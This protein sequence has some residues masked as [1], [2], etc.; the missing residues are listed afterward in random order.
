MNKLSTIGERIEHLRTEKRATQ[1]ELAASIGV[2]RETIHQWESG[3]RDLKT[4]AIIKLAQHFNVSA[5][6]LLGLSDVMAFD[7]DTQRLHSVTGLS[8]DAIKTLKEWNDGGT[9]TI[10]STS[11]R[12]G[13]VETVSTSTNITATVTAV[14]D[15]VN[16]LLGTEHGSE[17]LHAMHEYLAFQIPVDTVKIMP[18]V[19]KKHDSSSVEISSKVVENALFPTVEQSLSRLKEYTRLSGFYVE[20]EKRA[21]ERFTERLMLINE[22]S[23]RMSELRTKGGGDNGKHSE[24][25]R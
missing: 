25:L 4:G 5:D 3:T 6:W 10:S 1:A 23:K 13:D 19:N 17:V 14:I 11:T 20:A 15:T 2:K 12:E 9:A 24:T 22:E 8:E 18:W 7:S 16:L 21:W